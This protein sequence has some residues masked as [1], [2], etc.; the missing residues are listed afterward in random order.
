[1]SYMSK[2]TVIAAG[3]ALAVSLPVQAVD[4]LVVNGYVKSSSGAPVTSS[5]GECVRTSYK[6]TQELLEKCGYKRV[7]KEVV[8]V[9][10][11]P[12]GAGVAVIKETEIVKDAVVLAEKKEIIA[13]TF[14]QNLAFGFDNAELT[15]ADKAELDSVIAKLDAHRPLLRQNVEHLNIIGYT[16]SVGPESYNQKLSERRAQA[17]ADYFATSGNVRR[18]VMKVMGRGESNPIGDN[19]TEEGRALNR[20][21]VIEVVKH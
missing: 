12:A 11:Q 6:D 17:V 16:D 20:R 14:I 19:N 7:E 8:E 13:E 18:E 5:S 21:V 15:A 4:N 10:N 9:D 1:M 3:I 2:K